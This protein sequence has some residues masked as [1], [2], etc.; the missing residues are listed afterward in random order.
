MYGQNIW[1]SI[2]GGEALRRACSAVL[3]NRGVTL[4]GRAYDLSQSKDQAEA[5]LLNAV[6]EVMGELRRQTG[7]SS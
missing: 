4:W 5:F 3:D 1:V 6:T 2:A 7:E